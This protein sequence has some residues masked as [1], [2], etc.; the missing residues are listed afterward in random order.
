MINTPGEWLAGLRVQPRVVLQEEGRESTHFTWEPY[1]GHVL[2]CDMGVCVGLALSVRSI[3]PGHLR[4]VALLLAASEATL[5]SA[6]HYTAARWWL[7]QRYPSD[8]LATA[9]GAEEA[10]AQLQTQVAY[11]EQQCTVNGGL[12]SATGKTVLRLA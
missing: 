8:A 12:Q 1:S 10:L 9:E 11:I 2:R 4:R 6:L 3:A 7:W 5:N